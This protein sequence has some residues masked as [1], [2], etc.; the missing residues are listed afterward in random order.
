MGNMV[1]Y[2]G[3]C[4]SASYLEALNE[5][6]LFTTYLLWLMLA[7]ANSW[8]FTKRAGLK[9]SVCLELPVSNMGLP[10]ITPKISQNIEFTQ[11]IWAVDGEQHQ[12][13]DLGD[14]QFLRHT[15]VLLSVLQKSA[16]PHIAAHI[17]NYIPWKMSLKKWLTEIP[18]TSMSISISPLYPIT[19]HIS[20]H[21]Y[22]L[23]H[24]IHLYPIYIWT[25]PWHGFVWK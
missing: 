16:D 8:C 10:W 17:P 11:N 23:Y 6:S 4:G 14:T 22:P 21:S 13:P 12:R 2:R 24:Y 1:F 7:Q 20:Y 5:Q 9:C 19:S 25:L 15:S 18:M 3:Q